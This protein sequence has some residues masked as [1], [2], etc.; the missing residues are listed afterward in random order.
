MSLVANT[1]QAA[2]TTAACRHCG[3]P[4]PMTRVDGFCCAGCLTVSRLLSEAGLE[5]YYQLRPAK[6]APLLDYFERRPGLDWLEQE[7]GLALGR[8]DL[9]V[10]GV[11]CGACVWAIEQMA[12]RRS[13]SGSVQVNLNSVLGRLSL[14]FDPAQ[15]D[16]KRYLSDLADL[17]YRVRPYDA[18]APDPSRDLLYRLGACAAIT[19]NTMSFS[20]PFYLGLVDDGDALTRVF[21]SLSLG[22]TTLGV[23]YGGSYFFRRA[24]QAL[25]QGVSHFDIP[26]A[27]GIAAAYAGSLWSWHLGDRSSVYFDSV[28]VFLTL[29]LLGRFLQ[30]RAL[31]RQRRSL[32]KADSFASATTTV[33]DPAPHEVAWSAIETGQR[34][35]LQPGSL[36]PADAVLL[37][38]GPLE[39][40]LAS[41]TGERQPQALAKGAVVPAGARLVS[42]QAAK[43]CATAPFSASLLA[44]LLP[45]EQGDEELPVLW[46]WSVRYYVVLVLIAAFGGLGWWLMH[47]PSKALP[48]FIAVLVVTCPCGLGIAVPLGRTLADRRLSAA[49]LTIRQPGLLERLHHVERVWLDKTGTL[50]LADLEL[51]DPKA[52]D[53]LD[54]AGLGA[55]MGAAGASRHPVSRAIYRELS[56][57]GVPYPEHGTALETPGRGVSFIDAQGSWELGR[58]MGAT[59]RSW[60]QFSLNGQ[61][62][63]RFELKERL[64]E[65][66]REAVAKLQSMGLRVGLLSG[67]RNERVDALARSLGLSPAETR[68]ECSPEDKAQAVASEA[69]L[70]LGDGLNDGLALRGAVA[71]G[72][73]AWERSSLADQSD[74]SFSSA[75]LAWLPELF[76]TAKALRHALWA[77][78]AFAAIYNVGLVILALRGGFS[79]LLCSITMP[80][81]S[82]LVIALTAR[83]VARR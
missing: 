81:S 33:L 39:F 50:T 9:G 24:W 1:F 71:S 68:A 28:N 5:R 75:S 61:V 82:L 51:A 15:F 31:L 63:A 21:R 3:N 56:A 11:Q 55:L 25:R 18:T 43:V 41:L 20:L 36:C 37:D 19:M 12:S 46:R 52:L 53:D 64:L 6:I 69:S 34:L 4:V 44:K 78:L 49:G 7:P 60:A 66:A 35:L 58:D 26:I 40:D 16:I 57:R 79:P 42:G 65:D 38:A 72:T 45:Q 62:L 10:E 76:A 47:D 59:G 74:F 48:V 22:L 14:R 17:G 23:L 70:M 29:M 30:E 13:R 80:G 8:L 32:L 83:T 77:N 27:M 67:D 54:A 73:P 2:G